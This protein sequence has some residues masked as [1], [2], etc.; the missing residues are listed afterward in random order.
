MQSKNN[1]KRRTIW[2]YLLCVE[3]VELRLAV[4]SS[5]QAEHLSLGAV[6]HVDQFLVP[7]PVTDGPGHTPKDD[8]VITH[9]Q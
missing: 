4:V 5:P 1:D 7:P 8:A 3:L 2:A 9:L 6:G